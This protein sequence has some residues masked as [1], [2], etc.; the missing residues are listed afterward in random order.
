S[1]VEHLEDCRRM[2]IEVVAPDVNASGADFTVANG[3]IHVALSAIK[4]CGRG[5]AEAI[6]AA[7]K[8]APFR[9]IFDL[10]ERLDPSQVG[11]A[12]LES[13]TKAGALDSLGGRRAQ[14]MAVL[15]RAMQSGAAMHADRRSGQKGL[16]EAFDEPD[17]SDSDARAALPDIPE[18]DERQ[19][20]A[21]E[22]EVLGYYL[23]SHP[24]AEHERALAMYC[25]HNTLELAALP[26]RSEV[27]LGGMLSAIKYS[28]TKNPRAGSSNTKYAMFDL[29][30]MQGAVRCICWPEQYAE[31]GHLIEPDAALVVRGTVDRRAGSEE[32]NLLVNE[33]IPLAEAAS[34]FTRGVRIRLAE[35]LADKQL[36]DL[37]E[38]L[39]GYPGKCELNLV[40]ALEDGSR[41][42]LKSETMAV[43]LDPEMRSRIDALLGPGNFQLIAAPPATRKPSSTGGNGSRVLARR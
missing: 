25:T 19:R 43:D 34:R 4:G 17:A 29:E 11:R 3:K 18:W 32:S 40:V 5:A 31:L 16:F 38:I 28:Q 23:S 30:D 9:D 21:M 1:L 22:K 8:R 41:V 7:R 39:R 26:A 14:H 33:L 10:C 12:T 37:R 36:Q 6:E 42:H 20:L 27:V 15:E 13:L 24:L 35:N 2:D